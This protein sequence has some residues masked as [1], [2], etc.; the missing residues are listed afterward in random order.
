MEYSLKFNSP[1]GEQIRYLA[2]KVKLT[3]K[4][5]KA[6]IKQWIKDSANCFSECMH[7]KQK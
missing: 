4:D 5:E 1:H 2:T 7:R 6:L 3:K